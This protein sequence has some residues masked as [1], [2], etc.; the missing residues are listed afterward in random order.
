MA[1]KIRNNNLENRTN[2]LKLPVAKKPTFVRIGLGVSLGYRRNKT[3]GTWVLRIANGKSGSTSKTI[4]TADDYDDADGIN[5]INYWEAQDKAKALARPREIALGGI[6]ITT[7]QATDAYLIFLEARNPRSA[8]DVKSRLKKHFLPKFG[9]KP[10]SSITKTD[11]EKW[12]AS[13]VSK[14]DD[15]E[16]VRKSKDTANRVLS[17]VKALLNL[18]IRDKSN[19]IIDDSAWRL[20]KPFHG[21]SKPRDIRY[22]DEEVHRLIISAPDE[23]TSDL[24]KGAYLTGARY[25][26]LAEAKVSNFDSQ[27]KTLSVNVGKTGNRNI[28]LQTSATAFLGKISSGRLSS[29]YLFL[30]TDGTKWKRSEQTRPIK[31]ALYKAGLP[32]TGSLYAFRHTYVSSAIEGGIPLNIIAENCGTSVRMIEKTYAKVLAEKRRD[33]IERGA[34]VYI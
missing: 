8:S 14:S 2:R 17:M 6:P 25:G 16:R 18:A 19:G 21:V 13:M 28:I 5:Y 31:A 32:S 12:L 27:T 23:A 34:P 1:R 33:F 7:E 24:I 26:E 3:A 9:S 20:V 4:G 30:K 22:T 11:L 29:D 15:P 10:V